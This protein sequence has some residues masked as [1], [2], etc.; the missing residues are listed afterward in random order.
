MPA[1]TA[2]MLESPLLEPCL[3]KVPRGS[4]RALKAYG[5]SLQ[6]HGLTRPAVVTRITFA[7]GPSV[8]DETLRSNS[9]SPTMKR[10]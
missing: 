10:Q 9:H 7:R 8:R 2:K 5:D 4:L 3:L 1:M 6:H